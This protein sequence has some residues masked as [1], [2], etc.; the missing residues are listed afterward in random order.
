IG[1]PD[2]RSMAASGPDP[3]GALALLLLRAVPTARL[4]AVLHSLRVKGPANDLVANTR[5]VLHTAATDEHHRVFLQ[6]VTLTGN[7]GRDLDAVAQLH[8]GDLAQ[9]RVRLLGRGRVHAGAHTTTLRAPLERR[10]LL[11]CSLILAALTDQLL[12]RGQWTS[13]LLRL[14][15]LRC[16]PGPRGRACRPVSGS[17]DPSTSHRDCRGTPPDPTADRR[18]KRPAV[19]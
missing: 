5:Q 11:L 3:C 7:V 16:L 14:L 12:D 9:G 4:L 17:F 10:R 18:R 19:T 15:A 1:K 6:V 13:L 2:Q 8:T